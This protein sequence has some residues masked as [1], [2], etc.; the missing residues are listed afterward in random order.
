MRAR[1]CYSET[2]LDGNVLMGSVAPPERQRLVLDTRR[3]TP[4]TARRTR[5][6]IAASGSAH[7]IGAEKR[8]GGRRERGEDRPGA[9]LCIESWD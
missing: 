9:T 2:Q 4:E 1:A 5:V 7:E 8:R 6:H 3:E